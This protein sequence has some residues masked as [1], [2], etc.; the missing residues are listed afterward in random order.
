M[1]RF[2]KISLMVLLAAYLVGTLF[3][4]GNREKGAVCSS[5][6]VDIDSEENASLI[7]SE[8]VYDYLKRQDMLPIG[9]P[10]GE[11][12]LVA[13]ER[14]VSHISLL[15][16]IDC[17]YSSNGDVYL[18]AVQRRPFMRIF[19]SNGDNYYVDNKGE[20]IEVDT[21]YNDYLPLVMGH[22]D[23]NYPA[24][25]LIPFISYIGN[26]PLWCVQVDQIKVTPE[27]EIILYPRL[28]NHVIELGALADYKAK[29]DNVEA[30]YEQ[31]LPQVGWAAYDTI[32]V[33]YKDQVVCTRRDKTY[34]HKMYDKTTKK[35]I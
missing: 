6:Y 11:I 2:L 28:G 3:V 30:L 16:D 34:R 29:L 15:D 9:K 13:I 19:A 8:E 22:I 21:M 20:R 32:T 10:V 12:D 4:W 25:E 35:V 7:T 27:H 1:K 17:Y 14:C 31:V 33:K 24:T 5:F 26:H 18:K 23:E